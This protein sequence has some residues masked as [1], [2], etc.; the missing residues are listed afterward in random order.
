MISIILNL[1][2]INIF[3]TLV[4]YLDAPQEMTNRFVEIFTKGKVKRVELKKPFSCP[5]CVCNYLSFIYLL[6]VM[7]LNSFLLIC[8]LSVA[9]GFLTKFSSYAVQLIDQ[10]ISHLAML[11]ERLINKIR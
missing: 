11:M 1:F 5:L 9:N 3:I 8:L 4:Y 10:L 6:I 7:P 2:I